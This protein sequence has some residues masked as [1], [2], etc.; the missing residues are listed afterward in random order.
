MSLTINSSIYLDNAATSWPKPDSVPQ[1]ISRFYREVGVAAHR[2]ASAKAAEVNRT[3]EQC[4]I[5][6]GRLL[7]ANPQQ[8]VFCFNGTDGLNMA[9]H[10]LVE[11]S[12]RVVTSTIEHNSVLRPLHAL[13]E[14][15]PIDLNIVGCQHGLIDI[16]EMRAAITPDTD[17]CC[18][19][20][21]SNVT[22]IIQPIESIA[23]ACQ[24]SNAL[25][26]VDACQSVGH[27]PVDFEALGADVL[28]ASGHKGLLGPLGTGLMCLS[29]KAKDRIQAT[30]LGGTG[31]QSEFLTQPNQL[32][33]KLE[34]GNLNV[35]GIFGLLA[36]LQFVKVRDVAFTAQHEAEL[37]T[38]LLGR[39][40]KNDRVMTYGS[41]ECKSTGVT[42]FNIDGQ[43]PQ[44]VAAL[45]DAAFGIQVRA[46]L[47]CA[48]LIHQE[49]GTTQIGGTIRVSPGVFNTIED[50][51][52]LC[53]AVDQISM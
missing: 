48:P 1:A 32:P 44:T 49:L 52:S 39:F 27:F 12:N 5:E 18:V 22:G 38:V 9:I 16:A 43:D 50:I 45:L 29:E 51:I 33:T 24:D 4:R 13:Q 25:L 37:K 30:R 46:G 20:H 53:D 42:S 2:G 36:G 10:G 3:V 23:K 26:I 34:A 31:T 11:T 8:T 28:I 15:K 6:I 19:S 35:G 17:L 21:V 40:A 41:S 47:H 7:N 14:S